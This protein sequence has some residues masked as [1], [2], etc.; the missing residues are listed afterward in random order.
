M[1]TLLRGV[2]WLLVLVLLGV[3]LLSVH[4]AIGEIWQASASRSWP[5][6]S[7]QII[8]SRVSSHHAGRSTHH[9]AQLRYQYLAQ[10][11]TR[12]GTRV[13]FGSVVGN[14]DE[15]QALVARYP[16]GAKVTVHVDPKQ[17]DQAVLEPRLLSR[18]VYW[19][20]PAMAATWLFLLWLWRFRKRLGAR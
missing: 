16:L 4:W 5:T 9:V 10:G 8:E 15:V 3:S 1:K 12:E 7:G 14:L 19:V 11:Q 6:V 17:P 20:P 18:D 13:G 2:H